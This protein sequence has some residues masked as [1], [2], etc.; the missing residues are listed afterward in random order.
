M[1]FGD[2]CTLSGSTADV[3]MSYSMTVA[4]LI[5]FTEHET[6]SLMVANM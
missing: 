3:N 6:K 2:S 1:D 4:V 5:I